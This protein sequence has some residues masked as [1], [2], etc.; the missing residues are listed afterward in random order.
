MPRKIKV[1]RKDVTEPDEFISTTSRATA[2]VKNNYRVLF[3]IAGAVL[4]LVLITVI[5]SYYRSG[6][7]R[8]AREAFNQA[9]TLY[10]SGGSGGAEQP[11]DQTY[12]EALTRF[13]ALADD[14]GSTASAVTALFY[15][16]ESSYHLRDYD[17]AIEYYNR[18]LSRSRPGHYLRCFAYEGLGYCY[19]EKQGYAKAVDFYKQALAEPSPAVPDLLYGAVARCYEALNDKANALDYYK[20]I[21][22]AAS[23]SVLLTVAGD[24]LRALTP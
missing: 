13:T 1:Q 23:G 7:E 8:A 18:F 19:E 3:P 17:K 21:G 16:G 4:V 10:Q 14:Y 6:R 11:S 12:R 2:Y 9:V 15:L 22:A 24:R 5:W 20:K